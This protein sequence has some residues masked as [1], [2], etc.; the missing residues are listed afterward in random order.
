MPEPAAAGCPTCGVAVTDRF[1]AA[2]GEQT[3]TERDYSVA[4]YIGHV[5]ES[6]TNF[7]FRSLRAFGTLMRRPGQLTRYYLD[8]RRRLYISPVQLLVIVND[9]FALAGP[10]TFRTPLAF[11]E[12]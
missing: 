6:L 3:I 4:H 5:F 9:V 1:C 11:Q 7:D 10:A 12:S 2:C 8:G